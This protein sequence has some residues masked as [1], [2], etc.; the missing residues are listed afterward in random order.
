MYSAKKEAG[1]QLIYVI[2]MTNKIV[3]RIPEIIALEKVSG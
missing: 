3:K 2:Y 1:K